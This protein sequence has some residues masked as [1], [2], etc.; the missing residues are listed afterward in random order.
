VLRAN[1]RKIAEKLVI[2]W[3]SG[4][5]AEQDGDTLRALL[6]TSERADMNASAHIEGREDIEHA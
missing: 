2:F 3:V 4:Q 5:I 6:D 1:A